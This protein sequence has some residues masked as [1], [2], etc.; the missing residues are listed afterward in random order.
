MQNPKPLTIEQT[1]MLAQEKIRNPERWTVYSLAHSMPGVR[2]L[3]EA[4][5]NNDYSLW[6]TNSAAVSWC[7]AGAILAVQNA[8]TYSMSGTFEVFEILH[9]AASQLYKTDFVTVNNRIGHDA[10][11]A[12]FDR[13]RELAREPVAEAA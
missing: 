9:R 8:P 6:P 4:L 1:L 12:V 2:S 11:M 10:I 3:E 13:A 7:A 5:A